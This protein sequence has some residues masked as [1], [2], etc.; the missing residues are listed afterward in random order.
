MTDLFLQDF[1]GL[2][3]KK[4]VQI[5]SSEQRKMFGEQKP[6]L[7]KTGDA[8]LFLNSLAGL[9]IKAIKARREKCYR[10]KS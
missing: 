8:R 3:S 7:N 4:L 6:H 5:L 2:S 9:I 1:S 10:Q